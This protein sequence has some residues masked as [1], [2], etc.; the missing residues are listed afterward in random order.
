MT[1]GESIES[2][3][4]PSSRLSATE[5][6]GEGARVWLPPIDK[7]S[8]LL[9]IETSKRGIGG[10]LLYT[11]VPLGFGLMLLVLSRPEVR[12]YSVPL[13]IF[14]MVLAG[15]PGGFLLRVLIKG[16]IGIIVD[17]YGIVI[18][19]SPLSSGRIL[20]TDITKAELVPRRSGAYIGLDVVDRKKYKISR[21]NLLFNH[22]PFV[23]TA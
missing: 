17:R 19:T 5:V 14:F 9:I 15:L 22:Y 21:F 18:N 8:G 11:I 16:Q 20:W 4:D 3:T 10:L 2:I 23:I 1:A 7:E 6:I 12:S 13:G